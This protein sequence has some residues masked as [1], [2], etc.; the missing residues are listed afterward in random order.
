[1]AA[2]FAAQR[3]DAL[4][5]ALAEA[6]ER[7]GVQ[8]PESAAHDRDELLG[9]LDERDA[10]ARV[11]AALAAQDRLVRGPPQLDRLPGVLQ[12]AG[13]EGL[14]AGEGIAE[15]RRPDR[16]DREHELAAPARRLEVPVVH[17]EGDR[18]RDRVGEVPRVVVVHVRERE[19]PLAAVDR[20]DVLLGAEAAPLRERRPRRALLPLAEAEPEA[21]GLAEDGA[22]RLAR[23]P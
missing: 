8:A 6:R 21:R 9:P 23:A 13:L 11:D 20:D 5:L 17:R 4:H 16:V 1:G 18:L 14:H 7:D 15:A 2:R 10:P 19:G 22:R 3:G 12:E